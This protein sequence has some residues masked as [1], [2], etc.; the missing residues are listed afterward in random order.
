MCILADAGDGNPGGVIIGLGIPGGGWPIIVLRGVC[1]GPSGTCWGAV[2][3]SPVSSFSRSSSLIAFTGGGFFMKRLGGISP[4]GGMAVTMAS[5]SNAGEKGLL[6]L[7]FLS[8]SA[9][10]NS[11]SG[12]CRVLTG[13]LFAFSLS[14]LEGDPQ[15]LEDGEIRSCIEVVDEGLDSGE[16]PSQTG[17]TPD[18]C[19]IS[20]CLDLLGMGME[21]ASSSSTSLVKFCSRIS[22]LEGI[23]SISKCFHNS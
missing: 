3:L 14:S 12:D 4:G 21:S 20:L 6:S 13:P 15:M 8:L 22:Y 9:F 10:S 18:G 5:S 2:L 11:A 7:R 1:F 23:D 16:V 17:L 19:L